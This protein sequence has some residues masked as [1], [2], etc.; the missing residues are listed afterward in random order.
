LM[1]GTK[2]KGPSRYTVHQKR[3]QNLSRQGVWD[4]GGGRFRTDQKKRLGKRRKG[5]GHT[6]YGRQQQRENGEKSHQRQGSPGKKGDLQKG[7]LPSTK[8]PKGT[9][10]CGQV[11]R[12]LHAKAGRRKVKLKNKLLAEERKRDG[13][14]PPKLKGL[15]NTSWTEQGGV[16]NV[17][18]NQGF[19]GLQRSIDR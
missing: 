19:Q 5:T 10:K 2:T 1:K 11:S 3:E 16:T 8:I 15:N 17:V 13:V 4:P 12:Q 7:A 14:P 9:R 6:G 18:N